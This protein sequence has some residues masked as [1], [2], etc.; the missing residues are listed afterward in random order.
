VK[1][2]R[3][4]FL[5]SGLQQELGKSP[6]SRP[7]H[8]SAGDHWVVPQ[9]ALPFSLDGLC[10]G[11]LRVVRGSRLYARQTD[12]RRGRVGDGWLLW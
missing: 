2:R 5:T 12:W 9:S 1:I 4:I 7:S 8:S 10:S 11:G 6:H 3:C